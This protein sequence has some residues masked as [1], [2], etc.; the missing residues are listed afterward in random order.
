V[1]N[2]AK[3][4]WGRKKSVGRGKR[5]KKGLSLQRIRLRL[6]ECC[7]QDGLE[8]TFG[9]ESIRERGGT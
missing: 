8:F 7:P 3:G 2:T 4:V 6:D 5:G 1:M 9:M